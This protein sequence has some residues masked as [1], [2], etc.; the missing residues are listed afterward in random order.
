M[1]EF[2]KTA[3]LLLL[4]LI[5]LGYLLPTAVAFLRGHHNRWAIFWTN[6]LLGWTFLGWAVSLIWATTQVRLTAAA[7]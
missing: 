3:F 4:A 6:L 2:G 7:A 5:T 1:L